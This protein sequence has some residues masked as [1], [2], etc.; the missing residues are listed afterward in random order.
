MS[1]LVDDFELS[2]MMRSVGLKM[3][4]IVHPECLG[5]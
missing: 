5:Y 4:S 3:P 1:R 2:E